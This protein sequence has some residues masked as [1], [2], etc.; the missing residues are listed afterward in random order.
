MWTY[1]HYVV[2][3]SH[4]TRLI[5]DPHFFQIEKEFIKRKLRYNKLIPY[6]R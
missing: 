5:K 1:T 6:Q 3:N 4:T 2:S